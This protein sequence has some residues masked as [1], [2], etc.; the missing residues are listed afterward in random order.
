[1]LFFG[2]QLHSFL[3]KIIFNNSAG[4][5]VSFDQNG[6]LA[7]GFDIVNWVTFPNQSIHHVKVGKIVP[8]VS[9]SNNFNIQDDAITWHS[10]FN[11]VGLVGAHFL[12]IF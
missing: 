12:N 3:K 2:L 7:S 11:Q 8:W 6:E 1:M 5:Q 4:D 9:S 10:S